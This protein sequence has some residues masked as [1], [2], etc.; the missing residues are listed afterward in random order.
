MAESACKDK[1]TGLARHQKTAVA[2]TRVLCR[3]GFPN[4]GVL[5][6]HSTGS[7]KTC[8][9]AAAFDAAWSDKRKLV[10]VSSV[11]GIAA[12]P[13]ARFHECATMT[14]RFKGKDLAAIEAA[15]QARGVEF[16]S[17]AQLAHVLQLHRP[18][19]TSSSDEVAA[20]KS[21]LAKSLVVIDEVHSLLTPLAG[22]QKEC[23][24]LLKF[25]QTADDERT[26]DMRVLLLT[27]TPGDSVPDVLKMLNVVRRPG[28]PELTWT[29]STDSRAFS[30]KLRGLVSF[31][32][33]SADLTRFPRVLTE[34]HSVE[35]SLDQALELTKKVGVDA[36]DAGPETD[37]KADVRRM[38]QPARRYSNTLYS[39]PK[40]MDIGTFSAKLAALLD[41]VMKHPDGKHFVYSAFGERR[42]YGGHGA[43]AIVKA[44]VDHAGFR[45]YPVPADSK[46]NKPVVALLARAQP[47]ERIKTAFNS[48]DNPRGEKIRV[49]VAT[50]GFNESVDLKGV[51]HVHMFE[52]LTSAEDEKQLLGRGVR[53]CSH[54]Q[55]K[56]PDEWTVTVHRYESVVPDVSIAKKDTGDDVSNASEYVSRLAAEIEALKGVRGSPAARARREQ[57]RKL[58]KRAKDKLKLTK[59][60]LK[61]LELVSSAPSVD[62]QVIQLTRTRGEAVEKLLHVLRESAIDCEVFKAFHAK[63][64]IDIACRFSGKGAT[65]PSTP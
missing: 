44:L 4:R 42:G 24:A 18:R 20:M 60:D 31:F 55:L 23:A 11:V 41:T 34:E 19:A 46:D 38:W 45:Q 26:K 27:A 40:G 48:D 14:P 30:R 29:P 47:I 13:P 36:L 28:S 52:P 54:A 58:V 65:P 51:R 2:I 57:L 6:W 32:D 10:Y 56:Y 61:R 8:S 50:S 3:K 49:L 39:W 5:V 33:F 22:Q 43:R 53:M 1:R 62:S 21:Y 64:G 17:F 59:D 25:L 9:A 7:G 37:D 12:N 15:Y 63:A 16:L 35:M